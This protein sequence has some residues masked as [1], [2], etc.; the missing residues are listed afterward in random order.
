MSPLLEKRFLLIVFHG[1]CRVYKLTYV[2]IHIC[3]LCWCQEKLKGT[4]TF[5]YVKTIS[6]FTNNGTF[7]NMIN[8]N[9]SY[10][11]VNVEFNISYDYLN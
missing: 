2:V 1:Q 5:I 3:H 6:I 8:V 9:V 7:V 11:F 4:L 10:T